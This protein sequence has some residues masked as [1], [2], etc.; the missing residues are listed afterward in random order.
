MGQTAASS[1]VRTFARAGALDQPLEFWANDFWQTT[2]A[3]GNRIQPRA[4]LIFTKVDEVSVE[5]VVELLIPVFVCQLRR[6]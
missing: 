5:I 1:G 3:W 6:G 4:R 2:R